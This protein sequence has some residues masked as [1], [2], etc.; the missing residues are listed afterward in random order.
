MMRLLLD[1]H[2]SP[3]VSRP[4]RAAGID[5]FTLD[6]WQGGFYRH[7]PDED[8]LAAAVAEQR[9][10]VTYDEQSI[11]DL[12]RAWGVVGRAHGGI[13]FVNNRTIRQQDFGGQIRALR[14]LIEERGDEDWTDQVS[15][16]RPA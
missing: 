10:L 3:A 9:T 13:V 16:L 2:F 7:K 4:L 15:H 1:G 6:E 5:V 8:I 12:L 14:R 11:P